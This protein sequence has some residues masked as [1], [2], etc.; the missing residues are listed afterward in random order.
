MAEYQWLED[1]RRLTACGGWI[2]LPGWTIVRMAGKD[3][4]R[5]LHGLCTNDIL[6]LQAGKGCEA[7]IT[8]V[9]GKT[10]GHLIVL[11]DSDALWLVGAPGQA[12]SLL[13]HFERYQI[14]EELDL[15]DLTDQWV[16]IAIGGPV[17]IQLLATAGWDSTPTERYQHVGSGSP[18][19]PR[20]WVQWVP[21]ENLSLVIIRRD[22]WNTWPGTL[23][24]LGIEPVN[25][26]AWEAL[27]IEV[28]W[29]MYGLDISEENFPQ[30]I[31]RDTLAIS[32]RKGCY[33][34]QETV[35]RIDALGHVNRKLRGMVWPEGFSCSPGAYH[36]DGKISAYVTSFTFS[37]RLGAT[38]AM[39]YVR[40]AWQEPDQRVPIG[41]GKSARVVTFPVRAAA[42]MNHG[43]S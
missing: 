7:F 16:T 37:P 39:G 1:Y 29:P 35:A 19:N 42:A 8:S 2:E 30:E 11:F 28:G 18:D 43:A 13:R 36:H 20:R 23:Q 41:A 33:L 24:K 14:R 4:V 32:F 38:L 12:P 17:A 31:D 25:V 21:D 34:G 10:L 15:S 3:R 40:R 5:F 22:E 6:G 26:Q 9:Q 27:R